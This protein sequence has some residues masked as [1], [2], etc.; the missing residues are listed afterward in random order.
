[1]RAK[2]IDDKGENMAIQWSLWPGQANTV[3]NSPYKS[4][5]KSNI[6]PIM[7]NLLNSNLGLSSFLLPTVGIRILLPG[8]TGPGTLVW[9]GSFTD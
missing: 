7:S 6:N 3:L 8:V 2:A 1:M 9:P 4:P 5:L